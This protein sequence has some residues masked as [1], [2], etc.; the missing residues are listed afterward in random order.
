MSGPLK[1]LCKWGFPVWAVPKPKTNELRMVGDFRLLNKK[2]IPDE[3]AI[4]DMKE[5]VEQLAN[6]VVYSPLDFLK[7][8]HHLR[9]K[10]RLILV[11]EFGIM[12]IMSCLLV[13]Q[14]L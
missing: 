8:F 9:A 4:P 12:A 1:Q 7:A 10:E 5:T 13:L 14:V 3:S 2:T 11:T 6:A